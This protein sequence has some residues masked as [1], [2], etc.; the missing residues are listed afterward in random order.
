MPGV[1]A[2]STSSFG[3][4]S[5]APIERLRAAGFDVR[6]NPHGRTLTTDE[7][8]AHL[9]G[10]I[11]LVAGTEKLT[12]ELL[13]GLPEL[14][15]IARVGTGID[16]VDLA[17]AKELGIAVSNTPDAHVDAVAELT[18]AGLLGLLRGVPSSD[19]SI[20]GGGFAKPMGRLLRGKAVGFV[21]FGKV[22]RA[23]ARL[24][25]PW[26]ATLLATDPLPVEVGGVRFVALDDLLAASDVVS[27]HLPYS[28]AVH[29]LIGAN[30][31]ARMR[32][33]AIVVNT[34]RGGLIDEAA[35]VAHLG[36][37]PKAGAYLDCFEKEPYSGPLAALPNVV[38]TAH[39]GSY[40]R[41]ARIRMESEAVDNL[42]GALA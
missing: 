38:L 26:G 41:E 2:I 7:A 30:Q 4:E 25:A 15:A 19:A 17:A 18:L 12:G 33:D 5:G 34:S 9:A 28:K 42:L 23:L 20:R 11:G 27:L 35:L 3:K 22:A 37:H 13:R 31:L 32:D 36:A 8:R 16:N 6:P 1:V 40:A 24:L 39:V 14:K 29:H 10:V 21:G